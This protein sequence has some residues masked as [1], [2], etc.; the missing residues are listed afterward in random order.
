MKRKL[1]TILTLIAFLM[2]FNGSQA[3]ESIHPTGGD[4][5]GNGGSIAYSIGQL[6]YTHHADNGGVVAEGVQHAYEIYTVGLK[7]EKMYDISLNV[8]P[9]PTTE[10]LT[11]QIENFNNEEFSFQLFNATGKL[12]DIGQITAQQTYFDMKN[13]SPAIYLIHILDSKNQNIQTF[14]VIKQ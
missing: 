8:F 9:N 3:Q 13:L 5:T 11:L 7:K 14:K 4:A 10:S 12:L 6:V 1:Q 2:A